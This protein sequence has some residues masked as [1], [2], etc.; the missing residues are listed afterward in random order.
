MTTRETILEL[1]RQGI[2]RQVIANQLGLSWSGVDYHLHPDKRKHH[3][4]LKQIRGKRLIEELKFKAGYRCCR[5]GY[6]KNSAALHFH[7]M[8]HTQ[9][10]FSISNG[11]RRGVTAIKREVN[12]CQLLCANCHIELTYPEKEIY[13]E[14]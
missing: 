3:S 14:E 11:A 5:C 2:T 9:K 12:K 6:N 1:F 7:H 10:K 4:A 13:G 8:D